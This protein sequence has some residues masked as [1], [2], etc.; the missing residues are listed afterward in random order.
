MGSLPHFAKKKDGEMS[1]ENVKCCLFATEYDFLTHKLT[2]SFQIID[3]SFKHKGYER[4][5]DFGL[6]SFCPNYFDPNFLIQTFEAKR[7]IGQRVS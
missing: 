5:E 6:N 3:A 2:S 7:D 1:N 4:S